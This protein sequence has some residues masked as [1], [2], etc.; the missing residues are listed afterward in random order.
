ML[1]AYL[2]RDIH[3]FLKGA[4]LLCGAAVLMSFKSSAVDA[5]GAIENRV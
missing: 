1:S 2:V 5:V 3:K 4:I